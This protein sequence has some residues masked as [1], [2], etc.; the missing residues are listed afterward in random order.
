R[1]LT[2]DRLPIPAAMAVGAV[3]ARLVEANLRC[4]ANIII[5]TGAFAHHLFGFVTQIQHRLF[6]IFLLRIEVDVKNGVAIV[7]IA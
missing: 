7:L 1:A 4:D 3:Q 2:A 5:E 6:E